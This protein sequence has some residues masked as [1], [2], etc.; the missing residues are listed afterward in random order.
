MANESND[1]YKDANLLVGDT[2][3]NYRTVASFAHNELI[4]QRYQD[5]LLIP[6]QKGLKKSHQI[7][8]T[9]GFSQFVQFATFATLFYAASQFLKNLTIGLDTLTESENMFIALFSMMFGAF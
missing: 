6:Y 5:Y 1:N 7:G 9:F 3:T 8:I 4:L 2:I